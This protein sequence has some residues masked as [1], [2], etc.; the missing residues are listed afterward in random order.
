[1]LKLENVV[2]EELITLKKPEL[3]D[4]LVNWVRIYKQDTTPY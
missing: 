3:I 1:M 4:K 2:Q